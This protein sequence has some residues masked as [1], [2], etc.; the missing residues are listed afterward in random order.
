MKSKGDNVCIYDADIDIPTSR[1]LLFTVMS[2]PPRGF[3]VCPHD[4][5]VCKQAFFHHVI[6]HPE[7]D[8]C[9]QN[10]F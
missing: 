1:Q 5:P 3:L 9:F 6:Q 7:K 2:L 8:E 10:V 4:I